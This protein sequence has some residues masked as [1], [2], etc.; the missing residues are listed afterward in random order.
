VAP[1]RRLLHYA[2]MWIEHGAYFS[3]TVRERL[4]AP[5]MTQR[6]LIGA[7]LEV[8][9]LLAES[10]RV[11]PV[12]RELGRSTISLLR[13]FGLTRSWREQR[14]SGGVPR[15]YTPDATT[16]SLRAGGQ[17]RVAAPPC[18][19]IDALLGTLRRTL[20]PLCDAARRDD[21]QLYLCG[22]D[23]RN[24]ILDVPLQIET[25]YNAKLTSYLD[26]LGPSGARF[27]RQS[28]GLAI[29]IESGAEPGVRWR[30][31]SALAPYLT[32]MFAAS[33]RYADLDSGLQSYRAYCRRSLDSTRTGVQC[34]DGDPSDAYLDFALDAVD[35]MRRS[36]GRYLAYRDWIALGEWSEESWQ[37]HLTTLLPE[38]RP[39]GHL[40]LCSIDA[41]PLRWLAVPIV[42]SSG[43]LYDEETAE[44]V[45]ALVADTDEAILWRA[46]ALGLHDERMSGIARDLAD[47]GL[48]GARA[49]GASFVSSAALGVAREFCEQ[50]TWR[51]RAFAD[52]E[53]LPV[54]SP[55]P[56]PRLVVINGAFGLA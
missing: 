16:I 39:C 24:N 47:L 46:A 50:Y 43:L 33:R 11:A 44:E 52:D 27:M 20:E 21:I 26:T 5:S 36:N 10:G 40:E 38:V 45:A 51:S 18:A 53:P 41:V 30:L 42:L 29:Q 7:S 14:D 54:S 23:P 15:F 56:A 48:R 4:F 37:R 19:S 35:P 25:E 28:A 1:P 49:L 13:R 2:A 12:Q 22:I 3:R 34:A 55:A 6:P 17:I 9:P 32:A 8:I 31:A